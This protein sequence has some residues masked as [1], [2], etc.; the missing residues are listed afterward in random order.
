MLL[1]L[2][3]LQTSKPHIST[4]YISYQC[5]DYETLD[6]AK[7]R[8]RTFILGKMKVRTFI[9]CKMRVRIKLFYV[10]FAIIL[11]FP[12]IGFLA[13]LPSFLQV[14]NAH[15]PF[16]SRSPRPPRLLQQ[17]R[18]ALAY[19]SRSA[20]PP[21]LTCPTETRGMGV[22]KL[23]LKKK[24]QKCNPLQRVHCKSFV[25]AVLLTRFWCPNVRE[26]R[27][28]SIGLGCFKLIK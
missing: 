10:Y 18:P 4:I 28:K 6:G 14:P 11:D 2:H 12:S 7:K 1:L 24:I 16:S 23:L 15:R 26:F 3:L 9:M 5:R 20:R 19:S 21:S 13:P 25:P 17:Q 27:Q 22:Q 8:V